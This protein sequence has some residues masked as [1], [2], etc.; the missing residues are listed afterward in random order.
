[1]KFPTVIVL[2]LIALALGITAYFVKFHNSEEAL[3]R[4]NIAPGEKLFSSL[5]VRDIYAVTLT[6]GEDVTHLIRG[7]N[8]VWGIKERNNYEINYE[9][10][11]D[12]LGSLN[13]LD[14]TQGYPT[15]EEYFSRFGLSDEIP[16]RDAELG[17]KGAIKV[18]M[19]GLNGDQ[20]AEI[21]LGKFSGSIRVGGRFVRITGDDSG[22]YAVAQTFPGVTANPKD[23]LSKGFLKIDQMQSITVTSPADPDFADWK[24]MREDAQSQFWLVDMKP[25]EIMKLTS[26]NA[27][28]NFFNYSSFRDLLTEEKVAE[29][30]EPDEKLRRNAVITTFDGL[31]YTLE[32]WP[33]KPLP[34]D[35]NADDRLPPPAI[36]YNLT[37][38]ISADPETKLEEAAQEKLDAAKDFEGHIFEISGSIIAPLQKMRS[39]FY[40]IKKTSEPP[41]S[42]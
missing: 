10:L 22:V 33:H 19:L 36:S 23:W 15:S 3:A 5:P 9:L 35:P 31:S 24:L 40:T 42:Q 11:R 8:N 21:S 39:D 7:E 16:E 1:M 2:W 12:L 26:T 32:F 14:I 4:T 13:S 34:K 27:F 37:V 17:Y 6:Q 25:N 29:L 38:T 20:L 30:S 28:K 18:T 41:L